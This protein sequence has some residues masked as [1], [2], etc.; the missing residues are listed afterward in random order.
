MAN[1]KILTKEYNIIVD[2]L[3]AAG[4]HGLR[5]RTSKKMRKG[6]YLV[7]ISSEAPT[8]PELKSILKKLTDAPIEVSNSAFKIQFMSGMLEG[9]INTDGLILT[10][11]PTQA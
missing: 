6:T 2:S 9:V 5:L 8:K 10:Y 3:S 1:M 4:F 11:I 7:F